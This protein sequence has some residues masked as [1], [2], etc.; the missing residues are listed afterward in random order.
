MVYFKDAPI[1]P[2]KINIQQL[3]GVQEFRSS[4]SGKGGLYSV[5]EDQAG[6]ESSL[7]AHLSAIAQKFAAQ[8]REVVYA[9]DN[10]GK[11]VPQADTELSDED[12]YG[13]IDYLE[14]YE[15]RQA[16]MISAIE[17]IN[18][19]TVRVGEQ[20]AQRSKEMQSSKAGDAKAIRRLIKRTADDMNGYADTLTNQ[21]PML[22]TSREV[23]FSALSNALAPG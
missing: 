2:S 11:N 20:L 21:V 12:D 19:A 9:T 10:G 7:R 18:E 8:R 6:F 14:I 17:V 23:A 13:Y 22:S 1:S 15:S 3:Q 5:F 16:E 4:L